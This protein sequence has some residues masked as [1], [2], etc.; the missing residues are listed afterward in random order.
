MTT[1][2]RAVPDPQ[3]AHTTSQVAIY[4]LLRWGLCHTLACGVV[5]RRMQ[6]LP[7][8]TTRE[9]LALEAPKGGRSIM[10]SMPLT[11]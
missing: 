4:R 1:A 10:L 5:N 6:Q 3:Q 2:L 11:T 7:T 9:W 8:S